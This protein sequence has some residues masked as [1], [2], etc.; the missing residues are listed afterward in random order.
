MFWVRESLSKSG[1]PSALRTTF[2]RIEPGLR[3][4]ANIAGSSSSDSLISFA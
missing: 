2:S 1:V 4:V 3:V